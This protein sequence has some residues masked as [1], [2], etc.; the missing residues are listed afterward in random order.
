[1]LLAVAAQ[2]AGLCKAD[3]VLCNGRVVTIVLA[4]YVI[5]LNVSVVCRRIQVLK[6]GPF[7]AS[8]RIDLTTSVSMAVLRWATGR[9]SVVRCRRCA[10]GPLLKG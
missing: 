9:V 10:A 5:G 2:S 4:P 8:F 7:A 3:V 1:M 6:D